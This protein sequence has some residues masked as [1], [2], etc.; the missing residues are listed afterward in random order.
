MK[1]YFFVLAAVFF[2]NQLTAQLVP[3]GREQDTTLLDEVVL[4][5]GKFEQKQSQ[6]GK[7]VSVISKEQLEKCAGK[8]VAQVLSEQAGIVIAGAY[9]A[10]GSVQTVFMRGGSSGRTLILLDGIPL[11]DPSMIN[12]EF[13][14]NLFSINDVERI[15]VCR[16]AQSTLYG[17]DAIAGAINIITVKKD[18]NTPFN[19]KLTSAYGNLNTMRNN[20]QLHG[21]ISN[22][23]TYTT[24]FAKQSTDGFSSANDRNNA[25]N[26]DKDS[27]DGNMANAALQYQL[28]PSLS[29]RTFLQY[30]RY[31]A[32]IDA[33]VFND[34]RDY[35][36]NN[37][38]LATG[39]GARFKKGI[40]SI[41]YNYQYGNLKRRYL[42][43]SLHAPGFAK[44]ESNRYGGRTNFSE[45]YGNVFAS[46]WLTIL[47]GFDYRKGSMNQQYLSISSFGP[48][49]SEFENK[50]LHQSSFY[51]SV[52][53]STGDKKL[54][55]EIGGRLNKHSRYGRNS[56]YI[57]NPSYSFSK[58]VRMFGSIASG[59]KAPSIFQVFD[60]FS[61]NEDLKA[62]R[63]TNYEI[64]V[65]Q[66]HA[67]FSSRAVFFHRKIK[68]GID[69]NYN[70]FQY[71]NFVKQTVK[72]LELELTARPVKALSI[73][74]NY[75]FLAA[76]EE[77]QSRKSFG[78]TTY[79]HLMRRPKNSFNLNIGCQCLP[80]VFV[81]VSGRSVGNRFDTGGY[82]AEDVRM[83]AY[84]LVNAYAEYQHSKN[85]KIFADLQNITGKKFFDICGYNAIPFLI[86]GGITFNW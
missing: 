37:S 43:D 12:S 54:N 24:R 17:S 70:T 72:G 14:L 67:V 23:L 63:S 19:V 46:K 7:V 65:Q 18:V 77:T 11:N 40:V 59:F 74:A 51:S 73:S 33:G 5:A 68:N 25:G 32:D 27:Y 64:G 2:G 60:D 80:T 45:L 57:F 83:D 41:V 75:T 85:I 56:T 1:K 82:M 71:F 15:E 55:V 61:G 78:D 49:S 22:K 28:S 16:G 29:L 66:S 58:H 84:F 36:I 34:D 38:N 79:S 20:V 42:N 3:T 21:K 53:F 26:F 39:G 35:T 76:D 31:K 9:N 10:P 8:S 52:F 44:F 6:T 48:H 50:S 69:Y 13:D 30:S 47:A 62:E 81:R 4:T 86:S